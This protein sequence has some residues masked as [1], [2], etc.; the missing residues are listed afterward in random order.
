MKTTLKVLGIIVGLV[1]LFLLYVQLTYKQTFEADLTG[2]E[3]TSD[4]IV[5]ARGRYL[6]LGAAHCCTCHR[7]DS[8][9]KKGNR[10]QM[11]GGN[12]LKTPFAI[13]NTPNI[14]SDKETGIGNF[15]DEQ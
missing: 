11:I 6:V 13:F 5:V 4:S 2:I 14:T 12:P 10:E 3:S 7:P 8:M 1:C 9:A 15:T